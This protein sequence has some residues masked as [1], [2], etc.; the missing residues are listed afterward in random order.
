MRESYN[1]KTIRQSKEF[2][3]K[4]KAKYIFLIA[5]LVLNICIWA[6]VIKKILVS[7]YRS[8][9][10][11]RNYSLPKI[12]LYVVCNDFPDFDQK[13]STSTFSNC[14]YHSEESDIGLVSDMNS[15]N[16]PVIY[17]PNASSTVQDD[18]FRYQDIVRKFKISK[19]DL[20]GLFKKNQTE[21]E[22]YIKD[23]DNIDV[24]NIAIINVTNDKIMDTVDNLILFLDKMKENQSYKNISDFDYI[25]M[26]YLPNI[27]YKLTK[28][29]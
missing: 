29:K 17:I 26:R 20:Y 12:P 4:K 28:S 11:S 13:N 15:A 18:S 14:N 22:I 27:Y 24:S 6:F 23:Q 16:L 7:P 25:D 2:S 9:F 10:A 5:V 8:I 1:K 3:K 19:Y 21:S